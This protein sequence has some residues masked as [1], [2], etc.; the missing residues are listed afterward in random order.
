MSPGMSNLDSSERARFT[1]AIAR[2]DR[3]NAENL[4]QELVDGTLQRARTSERPCSQICQIYARH[5]G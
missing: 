1:D 4:N 2:F 5:R 3:A